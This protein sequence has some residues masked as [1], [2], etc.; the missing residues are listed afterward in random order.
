MRDR[1]Y[2][3]ALTRSS[4][5]TADGYRQIHFN[6]LLSGGGDGQ[7]ADHKQNFEQHLL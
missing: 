5:H 6:Y 7:K 3:T 4:M 1:A 2:F